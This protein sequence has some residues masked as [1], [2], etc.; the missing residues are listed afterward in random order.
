[1]AEL[2]RY[3]R[4]VLGIVEFYREYDDDKKESENS[5]KD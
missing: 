1:M 5:T 4:D 2:K 3:L